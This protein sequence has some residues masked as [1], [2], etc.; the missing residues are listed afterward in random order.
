MPGWHDATRELQSSEQ[1]Q[2]LGIVEEQHPDRAALFMQWKEMDWP[3]MVDSLDLLEVSAV[4]F[5]LLIDEGSTIRAINPRKADLEAFLDAE[6]PVM[7]F[8]RV[9]TTREELASGGQTPRERADAAFMWGS[10]HADLD[11]AI[12]AYRQILAETP[13]DGT[14]HFHLGVALRKRYDSV[15]RH[16][17][18]FAAAIQH[19]SRALELDPNQY[20]WRRR[21]QQYGP[22][23]DKPYPF[24][25]WVEEARGAISARGET[26]HTLPVEP[27]GAEYARPARQF[28]STE[29]S[30]REPDPG[31][32]IDRDNGEFVNA[33]IIAVPSTNRRQ[34]GKR[35]HVMFRPNAQRKAHWNNEESEL[36]VWVTPPE[37]WQ[38]D[39]Q[40]MTTPLATEP[41]STEV[42]HVEFELKFPNDLAPGTYDVPAYALYYVCEDVN[43]VCLYRRQDLR[44][45]VDVE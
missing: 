40:R 38:V 17:G 16:D 25:D 18:D 29:V 24:Y 10:T 4:P 15:A 23:L 30:D 9:T 8:K 20:I 41:A 11:R 13:D 28:A 6:P 19:W 2:V 26:P 36:L 35:I 14:T 1:L 7:G 42:R 32:R 33:E 34:R 27:S 3:L 37:G 43:G 22:R 31:G 12:D 44:I 5:T 21:I 45:S 39:H